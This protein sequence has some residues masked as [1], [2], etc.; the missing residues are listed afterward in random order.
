MT[1]PRSVTKSKRPEPT[2]GSRVRAQNSRTFGSMAF[3]AFGVNTRDI[4]PRCTSCSGGSSMRI[5]PG[6]R[7]TFGEDHLERRT[8]AGAIRVPVDESGF[9]VVEATQREE[10][11]LVVVVEGSLVTH[12][13]PQ[14]MRVVV[15]LD[16]ER[17]VVEVAHRPNRNCATGIAAGKDPVTPEAM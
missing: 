1:A 5:I 16:V 13:A 7:S 10:A 4:R 9:D 17:V 2:S 8:P 3:I 15:D 6:G 12:P 14:R 11:V